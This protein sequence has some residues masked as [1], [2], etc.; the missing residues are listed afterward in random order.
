MT[1]SQLAPAAVKDFV[2]EQLGCACPDAVFEDIRLTGKSGLFTTSN[3]LYEIGG[4][5]LVA[6]LTPAD[7]RELVAEIGHAVTAGKQYRDQ[8]GFNRFRLVVVADEDEA[9]TGLQLLFDDL[10][11]MDDKTHLHVIKP[12]ALPGDGYE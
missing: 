8:H 3:T 12:E 9:A 1:D 5:L 10:P 11:N 6:V 4:R 7:W 2:R